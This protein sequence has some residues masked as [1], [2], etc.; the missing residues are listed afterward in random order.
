M[1]EA[2]YKK[3][4]FANKEEYVAIQVAKFDDGIEWLSS[5]VEIYRNL[6]EI[7]FKKFSIGTLCTGRSSCLCLGAR[8]GTEV[9]VFNEHGIVSIGIDLNPGKNNKYVVTGDAS[10]IQFPDNAFDIVYTNSLDHFWEIE[11]VIEEVKRVLVPKGYFMFIISE[12]FGGDKYDAVRWQG[13]VPVV[14]YFESQDFELVQR[15]SLSVQWF[16]DFVI[17]RMK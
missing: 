4:E 1:I 14:K 3:R 15:S 17:M 8:Q 13:V 7:I 6:L 11:K 9:E 10:D 5:Y 2:P 12:D 16:T